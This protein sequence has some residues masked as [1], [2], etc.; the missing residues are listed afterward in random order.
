VT[1][2]GCHAM[3]SWMSTAGVIVPKCARQSV[4]SCILSSG[5]MALRSQQAPR[6]SIR[7]GSRAKFSFLCFFLKFSSLLVPLSLSLPSLSCHLISGRSDLQISRG[8]DALSQ[9]TG[10]TFDRTQLLQHHETSSFNTRRVGLRS[11]GTNNSSVSLSSHSAA[12]AALELQD[13]HKGGG[14]GRGK[15][16]LVS[17]PVVESH[18]VLVSTSAPDH[19]DDPT[20]V[21]RRYFA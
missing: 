16:D 10:L 1:V 12:R 7:F 3:V 19:Q 18:S 15:R 8:V 4:N 6:P 21:W 14:S 2:H 13:H 5:W 11:Q 17:E 9:Q 20:K